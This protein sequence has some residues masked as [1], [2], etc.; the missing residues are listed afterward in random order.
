MAA[1]LA[2]KDFTFTSPL[3]PCAPRMAPISTSRCDVADAGM[4]EP[5][6]PRLLSRSFGSLG[7]RVGLGLRA[8]LRL[9]LRLVL[10]G[11]LVALRRFA[12]AGLGEEMLDPIARRRAH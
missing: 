2:A 6:L 3:M 7:G 11:L 8:L 1:G 5:D 4:A 12:Q 9:G 10:L